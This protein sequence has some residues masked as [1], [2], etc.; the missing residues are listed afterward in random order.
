MNFN[1]CIII[2]QLKLIKIIVIKILYLWSMILI[3]KM[4]GYDIF[5]EGFS[6]VLGFIFWFFVYI[7]RMDPPND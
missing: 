2:L 4:M 5:F 1:L 3:L 6:I 7:Y